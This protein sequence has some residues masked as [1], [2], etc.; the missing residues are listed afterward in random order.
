MKAVLYCN[1]YLK[2]YSGHVKWIIHRQ[3]MIG[4]NIFQVLT[5]SPNSCNFILSFIQQVAHNVMANGQ[6]LAP[7]PSMEYSKWLVLLLQIEAQN[8]KESL[9][10]ILALR[11][12]VLLRSISQSQGRCIAVWPYC[13]PLGEGREL[14]V[15]LST[16]WIQYWLKAMHW[17]KCPEHLLIIWDKN[18]HLKEFT[19]M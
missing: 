4:S 5:V 3:F 10:R 13:D 6:N 14:K 8:S 16:Q 11:K 15:W 9:N 17:I 7:Q 1:V 18:K 12:M 2:H 19:H